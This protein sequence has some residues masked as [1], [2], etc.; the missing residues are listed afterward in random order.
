MNNHSNKYIKIFSIILLFIISINITFAEETN[1]SMN[2]TNENNETQ[3][4]E[5]ISISN[6]RGMEYQIINIGTEI[7][8]ETYD[9]YNETGKLT[10]CTRQIEVVRTQ[11]RLS[12]EPTEF[13]DIPL[14]EYERVDYESWNKKE[15]I[16][17]ITEIELEENIQENN[18]LQIESEENATILIINTII[19]FGLLILLYYLLKKIVKTRKKKELTPEEEVKKLLE[20]GMSEEYCEEVYDYLKTKQKMQERNIK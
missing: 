17:V 7:I 4:G 2:L 3:K 20:K 5:I 19:L 18:Y 16:E 8:N 11:I 10:R 1:E 13:P 6:H 15:K 12:Q 9:C 14:Q